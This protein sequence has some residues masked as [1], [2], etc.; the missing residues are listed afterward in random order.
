MMIEINKTE[1]NI[2]K[3]KNE[4]LT[5]KIML[6]FNFFSQTVSY[7]PNLKK[8]CKILQSFLI[9]NINNRPISRLIPYCKVF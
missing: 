8:L 7:S 4:K 2:N 3:L 6:L 5:F 9:K 1:C